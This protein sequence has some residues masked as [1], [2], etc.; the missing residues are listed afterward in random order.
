VPAKTRLFK[1]RGSLMGSKRL[2]CLW[3]VVKAYVG[4]VA[5]KKMAGPRINNGRIGDLLA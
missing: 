1:G 3:E 5:A 2:G 4:R